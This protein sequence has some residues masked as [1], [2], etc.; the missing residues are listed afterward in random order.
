MLYSSS[1]SNVTFALGGSNPPNEHQRQ[2][3]QSEEAP[4]VKR[5]PRPKN[6]PQPLRRIQSLPDGPQTVDLPMV[7]EE[8]RIAWAHEAI[9]SRIAA[10]SEMPRK[11]ESTPSLKGS[12]ESLQMIVAVKKRDNIRWLRAIGENERDVPFQAAR[13]I[14]LPTAVADFRLER[15]RAQVHNVVSER[16]AGYAAATCARRD[17]GVPSW[18]CVGEGRVVRDGF[19]VAAHGVD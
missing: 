8:N 15:C 6:I 2:P 5:S 13:I 4:T 3:K 17:S 12:G 10:N 1:V 7:Q 18:E 14:G 11:V 19:A 16:P 9:I